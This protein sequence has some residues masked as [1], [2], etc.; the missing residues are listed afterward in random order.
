MSNENNV[1]VLGLLPF[2]RYAVGPT[3]NSH[4]AMPF[5]RLES[6][7]KFFEETKN[8]LPWCGVALYERSGWSGIDVVRVYSPNSNLTERP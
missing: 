6:A 1:S 8:H 2:W 4:P 7:Q 3:H 5:Y